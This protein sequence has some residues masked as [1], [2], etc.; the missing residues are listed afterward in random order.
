MTIEAREFSKVSQILANIEPEKATPFYRWIAQHNRA[1]GKVDKAGRFFVQGYMVETD[2]LL[3]RVGEPDLDIAM[4]QRLKDFEKIIALVSTYRKERLNVEVDYQAVSPDE[5]TLVL[6]ANDMH[7]YF[8]EILRHTGAVYAKYPASGDQ[9]SNDPCYLS[10][11]TFADPEY[12]SLSAREWVKIGGSH[13]RKITDMRADGMDGSRLFYLGGY[14]ED[15]LKLISECNVPAQA[16]RPGSEREHHREKYIMTSYSESKN[17]FS[18]IFEDD[19]LR[20]V[21]QLGFIFNVSRVLVS[22]LTGDLK[23]T[24]LDTAGLLREVNLDYAMTMN[25]IVFDI[26]SL[27]DPSLLFVA[28]VYIG[29]L[30][31]LFA[32]TFVLLALTR[33]IR[34]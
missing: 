29:F 7:Y 26:I 25:K 9:R 5:K 30:Y 31:S 10:L 4:Y 23:D 34:A 28:K 18:G 15:H 3:L 13:A 27:K 6:F 32:P 21:S 17:R 20:K 1:S 8:Y 14:S 24:M 33:I 19:K 22:V 11:D 16:A 2:K 12:E